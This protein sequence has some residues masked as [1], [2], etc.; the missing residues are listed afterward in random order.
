MANILKLQVYL[1]F[2]ISFSVVTCMCQLLKLKLDMSTMRSNE[3]IHPFHHVCCNQLKGFF[4]DT[5][6]AQLTFYC[7]SFKLV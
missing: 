1:R 4:S 6:N 3:C 5:L 2:E 7:I